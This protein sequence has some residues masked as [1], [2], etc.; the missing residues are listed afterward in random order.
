MMIWFRKKFLRH[1]LVLYKVEYSKIES[2]ILIYAATSDGLI[3]ILASF[4]R[5]LSNKLVAFACLSHLPLLA[6][7]PHVFF[8]PKLARDTM[9]MLLMLNI[10]TQTLSFSL[11]PLF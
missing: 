6:L 4:S 7:L 2:K 3:E 11:F 8:N 10:S 9:Q 1:L 5:L